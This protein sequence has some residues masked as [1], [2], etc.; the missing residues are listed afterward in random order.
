MQ[1]RVFKRLD[2]ED[3]KYIEGTGLG[4]NI[5]SKFLELMGSELKVESD[6]GEGADFYF[7]LAY[8]HRKTK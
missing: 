2:L 7:A 4:L 5:T 1:E 6:I 3:N 8:Q